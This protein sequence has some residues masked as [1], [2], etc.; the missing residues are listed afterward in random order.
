MKTMTQGQLDAAAPSGLLITLVNA[1]RGAKPQE[2]AALRG[3]LDVAQETPGREE[4]GEDERASLGA[5]FRAATARLT[6]ERPK[7]QEQLAEAERRRDA[8]VEEERRL[9]ALIDGLT[10][11]AGAV[12]DEVY[13]VGWA[14]RPALADEILVGLR[15]EAE[16]LQPQSILGPPRYPFPGAPARTFG[17]G[18]SCDARRASLMALAESFERAVARCEVV[19]P[20]EMRRFVAEARKALPVLESPADVRDRVTAAEAA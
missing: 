14:G 18:E 1:I 5:K 15:A 7:L 17:N 8:A 4:M 2:R 20:D 10:I 16:A 12:Q 9:R 13:R 19:T 6:T 11:E 3:A